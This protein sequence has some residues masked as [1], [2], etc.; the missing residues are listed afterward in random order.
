MLVGRQLRVFPILQQRQQQFCVSGADHE[1]KN[2]KT[3]HKS[4]FIF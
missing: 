4:Q 2:M 1:G 3:A